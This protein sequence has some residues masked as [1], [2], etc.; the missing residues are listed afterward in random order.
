MNRYI[1]RD[2]LKANELRTHWLSV[3]NA[4]AAAVLLFMLLLSIFG[5]TV[6][7]DFARYSASVDV[8]DLEHDE[9]MVEEDERGWR[10]VK[11]DVFRFPQYK[12]LFCAVI[13]TGA[14]VL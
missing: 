5:R 7:R 12:E 8:E 2:R 1:E 13:G 3:I 6:N 11:S 14:Q 4:A 10:I 9:L